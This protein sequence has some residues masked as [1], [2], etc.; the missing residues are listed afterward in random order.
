MGG[1]GSTRLQ[2]PDSTGVK[3]ST[4]YLPYAATHPPTRPARRTFLNRKWRPPRPAMKAAR[5][6]EVHESVTMVWPGCSRRLMAA[7]RAM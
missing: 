3:R 2:V 6:L 5:P 1:V 4:S 7:M